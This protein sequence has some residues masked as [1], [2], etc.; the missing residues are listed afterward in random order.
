M[1]L[2]FFEGYETFDSTACFDRRYSLSVSPG[3]PTA[4]GR[5][6]GDSMLAGTTTI[7]RTRSLTL[8]NT[9]T[10]GFGF[11]YSN[12]T[13]LTDSNSFPLIWL[14]GTDEQ[15]SL[16]WDK[17]SGE[18]TFEFIL[19]RG[20]TE[21]ARTS[22]AGALGKFTALN[23]HYFEFQ[24]TI[25]PASGSYEFR[26][27]TQVVLSEAGPI[28][29]ADEGTAGADVAEFAWRNNRHNTDDMYI[30]DSTGAVNNTF[31]GDTVIEGR[32][33]T[34]EDLAVHDWLIEDGGAPSID[35]YNEVCDNLSCSAS[36]TQ[37]I[38][39]ATI[40]DDGMMT[41]NALSFITG[42]IH[43]VKVSSDAFL[44]TSGSRE[45]THLVRSGG[46]IYTPGITHTVSTT[47]PQSFEDII[48]LDP[49]TSVKWTVSGVNGAD[50]GV[51]LIS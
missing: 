49:D 43:A 5:L 13:I 15:F 46:T 26:H 21:V 17:V 35:T 45:F 40:N 37:Y 51:R 18:N 50:F 22:D 6:H 7:L 36:P 27:N 19:M 4:T 42:T 39:S 34:G 2:R 1:V 14:K 31:L 25:D 10:Y 29:T 20:S 30:L 11:R 44:D 48:E 9:W 24:I 47:N 23:W 33:P 32:L 16:K 8:Q 38:F 41:F 12:A 3:S 28:N